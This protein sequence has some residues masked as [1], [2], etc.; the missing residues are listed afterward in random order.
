[1]GKAAVVGC[2]E[3]EI[4]RAGTHFTTKKGDT[5]KKGEIITI[6]GTT[7]TVYRGEIPTVEPGLTP[8]F[9]RL[10]ELADKMRRLG[11][12]ANADTPE[13]ATR[14]REFGAQGIG[15]CRTER[16]FN[17]PR[18]LPIVREMIMS[19]DET[20]R[21]E[22]LYKLF[23]FQLEDFRA[24]FKAMKGK[25]VIV[26]L[27]DLPLHEFLP[28]AEDL[29]VEIDS[30]REKGGNDEAIKEKAV[31]LDR[32]RQLAEH[33]PMLGHRGCRL[34][35][36]YPEIYEMQTKAILTAAAGLLK[37]EGETVRVKIMLPLVSHVR[38]MEIL[39]GVVGNAAEAALKDANIKLHYEI[40]TMI[41]TPR[42][43]LTAEEI[44]K[45]ADFFS[46]GTNDLTQTTFAF[47]RDDVE[48]KFMPRYLQDKILEVSP[49]E[50]VDTKGVGRLVKLAVEG[51]KKAN[52]NLEV[53]IC[54]EHGGDP[55]SIRFFNEVGLD[56]VSC[57]G[58][59]LPIARLAAAQAA[60]ARKSA[61][62]TL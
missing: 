31:V 5:V 14:A 4:S 20:E 53:G 11:V 43:A 58:F 17:D 32:V 23:P 19:R 44:A 35:I 29:I 27:L 16:M 42:A 51:G 8:E 25:P 12:W 9:S 15:L 50:S 39:R 6:D 48:A 47:S 46:F 56:Y 21:R 24:I 30:L 37:E 59:R 60:V 54:G 36:T 55:N 49:F 13:G 41:E 33:N 1:M 61:T 10:L 2:S 62:T 28:T 18:R 57:S 26:R 34:A 45:F 3:I 7:G 22:K 40:G 52:P 38:E